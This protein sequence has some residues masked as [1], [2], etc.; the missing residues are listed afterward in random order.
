MTP[1]GI[2]PASFRFVAQ[3]LNHCAT[4]VPLRY[5]LYLLERGIFPNSSESSPRAAYCNDISEQ[6]F[7]LGEGQTAFRH[8]T[9]MFILM[10]NCVNVEVCGRS[11]AGRLMV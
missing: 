6:A 2:E 3:H 8:N 4:A 7:W 9:G 1:A 5:V 10:M 11:A